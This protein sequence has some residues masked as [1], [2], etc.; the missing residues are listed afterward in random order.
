MVTWV[1][2]LTFSA[3]TVDLENVDGC[4]LWHYPT[5]I[6]CEPPIR[7]KC[8]FKKFLVTILKKVKGN[9]LILVICCI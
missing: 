3:V 8:I 6:E 2:V 4:T 1:K 5:E 9:R 7:A